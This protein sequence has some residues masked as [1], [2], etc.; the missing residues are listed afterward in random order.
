MTCKQTFW[1]TFV[2]VATMLLTM[3]ATMWAD[4]TFGGGSGTSNDPYQIYNPSHFVQL[5]DEV[6]AGNSFEG[7]YFK[8]TSSIDFRLYG[9]IPPIGGQYYTDEEGATG[10]R[11]FNGYFLGDNRTLYNVT[12][13]DTFNDCGI[14][15]YLGYGGYVSDLKID[16]N[17]TFTGIG[18]VGAIVGRAAQNTSIFDCT[19]GENV[20]VKVHSDAAGSNYNPIAFGGIAGSTNG[21]VSG[22][23]SK[24][25]ITVSGIS[26]TKELGGIAGSVGSS[27]RI[28]F[29]YFLG[30]IDGTNTVG[31]IAGTG[32]GTILKCYYNTAVRHGG[33]NGVDTDGAKWMGSVTMADGVSGS[34]PS[35]TYTNGNTLYFAAGKYTLITGKLPV[36]LSRLRSAL[37]YFYHASRNGG[38]R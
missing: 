20:V 23:V 10:I 21:N 5:S 26:K 33:V 17:S 7:V 29:N 9:Q 14:F 1:R 15:G 28:D 19:V 3:P 36:T 6:K 37:R 11:S 24:A 16:G 12:I 2:A 25:T 22:C 34:L 13:T 32:N 8:L 38:N 35:A 4:S 18:Y 30:T 31:D 27:A